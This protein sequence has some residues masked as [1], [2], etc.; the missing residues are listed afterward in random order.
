VTV[1]I[2]EDDNI[3]WPKSRNENPLDISREA[4]LIDR[5]IEDARR[6]MR[7]QRKAARKVMVFQCPYGLL[8]I[9]H[10]RKKPVAVRQQ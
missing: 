4:D 8:A 2:V 3:A 5:T 6:S 9:R 7:S 10:A 1:Q